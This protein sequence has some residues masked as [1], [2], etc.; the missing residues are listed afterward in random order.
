MLVI[1]V[2]GIFNLP[3]D[4]LQSDYL[5]PILLHINLELI[6]QDVQG[7]CFFSLFFIIFTA[8]FQLPI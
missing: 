5:T 7:D 6:I 4:C 8:L 1:G 3:D 2:V